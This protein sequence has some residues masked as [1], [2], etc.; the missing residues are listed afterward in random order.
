MTLKDYMLL[1]TEKALK[2]FFENARKVPVDKTDWKPLDNGRSTLDQAQ[3][4]AFCPLWVPGLLEK[5]AFDPSG[6]ATY[7]ETRK[8]W[9]TLD[10][11]EAA[12]NANMEQFR[13]AVNALPE[14]DYDIKIDLP[15]G[16]YTLAEVMGFPMWN[17][18]YHLGQV[19]YIQT[20]YGD[21]SM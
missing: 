15:W 2:H 7:E 18:H 12:A 6:F 10:E 4:V 13:A 1:E 17:M 14:A 8:G 11:C 3:E 5:R 9:K 16:N 20:L 21:F 19:G